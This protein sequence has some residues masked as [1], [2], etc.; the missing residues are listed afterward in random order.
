MNPLERLTHCTT[1]R[2]GVVLV[3]AAIEMFAVSLT[4]AIGVPVI[5]A[6]SAAELLARVAAPANGTHC[7]RSHGSIPDPACADLRSTVLTLSAAAVRRH[8]PRELRRF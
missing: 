7:R 3:L 8:V 5:A 1:F 2:V 6:T 4:A